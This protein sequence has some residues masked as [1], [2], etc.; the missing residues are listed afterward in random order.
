[1]GRKFFFGA[2]TFSFRRPDAHRSSVCVLKNTYVHNI[3]PR[4]ITVCGSLNLNLHIQRKLVMATILN[5]K[6]N[7]LFVYHT[8]IK[9]FKPF[10][11]EPDSIRDSIRESMA[12]SIRDSIGNK[13]SRFAGL[14]YL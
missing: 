4:N 6:N 2:I 1:M 14:Y 9:K 7:N 11:C 5:L 3:T 13:K 8:K 12:N 10:D